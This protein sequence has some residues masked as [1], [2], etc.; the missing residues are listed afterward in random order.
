MLCDN[1]NNEEVDFHGQKRS[2]ATHVS[3]T[4]TEAKPY[5]KGKGNE[6][7]LSFMGHAMIENRHGL[8]VETGIN[9]PLARLSAKRPK[10]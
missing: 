8:V 10:R 1:W 7:K 3:T 6:A 5:R 9:S 2:N 4:D